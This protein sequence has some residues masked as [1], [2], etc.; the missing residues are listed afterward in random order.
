MEA[1]SYMQSPHFVFYELY[2]RKLL[3]CERYSPPKIQIVDMAPRERKTPYKEKG[4][5]DNMAKEIG[6]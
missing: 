5:F 2:L 6:S 1:S 3:C 4:N